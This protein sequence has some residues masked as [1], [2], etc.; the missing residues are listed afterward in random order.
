MSKR[1]KTGRLLK[2]KQKKKWSFLLKGN[3]LPILL[4]VF[5]FSSLMVL[6]STY[7]WFTSQD[8]KENNFVGTRL[9][10]EI[11]EDFEANYQWQP[12][13]TTQKVV[14]VK[15]TGDVPALIRV[16]F[17]EYLLL[18]EI[19][20]TDQTGNG[21]LKLS[22]T[23]I[24]PSVNSK[25]VETWEAAAQAGGTYSY[26]GKFYLA[27]EA[28]VPDRSTGTDMFKFQD[29]NRGNGPFKWFD[30]DIPSHVYTSTPAAGTK[31]YWLYSDG[32]FYYSEL[33]APRESTTPILNSILLNPSAPNKYKGALY[34]FNPVMDAHDATEV[35]LTAW[36][37][38]QSGIIHE[39]YRDYLEN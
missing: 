1:K 29:T 19:D 22:P 28:V 23:E 30:L 39:M 18:F 26:D 34:Q 25:N 2:K 6:G 12:G 3:K 11:D 9:A 37:L 7:A 10:A 17:Y 15:N 16:S 13:L 20:T 4:L 33:V 35:I 36:S 38:P 31:D 27:K 32:Y 21:N 14:R 8:E 5:F 24:T